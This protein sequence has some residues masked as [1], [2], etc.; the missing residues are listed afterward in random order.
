[1]AH[2]SYKTEAIVLGHIARGEANNVFILLTPDL[3]LLYAHGQGVRLEKSKL[4]FSL[5]DFSIIDAMLVHGKT[6]WRITNASP[7]VSCYYEMNKES[8][9]LTARIF[10]LIKKLVVGEEQNTELYTLCSSNI[11]GLL[12]KKISNEERARIEIVWVLKA[13]SILGYVDMQ[14]MQ[15]IENM[16]FDQVRLNTDIDSIKKDAL[17][18]IN[19][20]IESSHLYF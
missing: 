13:L 6:G 8:L 15:N 10:S 12:D 14:N 18:Q 19:R 5:Q 2:I 20:A 7:K 11:F 4:R 1:M 9:S 17:S 3:G 16:T